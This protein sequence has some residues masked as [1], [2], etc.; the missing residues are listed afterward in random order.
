PAHDPNDFEIGRR[1]SLP[2]PSVIGEDGRITDEAPEEFRGLTVADAQKL[3]VQRLTE[4][5][6]ITRQQP[7]EHD[8]PFSQR[9][10]ERIEPLISLQWFM[11]MDELVKPAIEVVGSGQVRFRPENY[12]RV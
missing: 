8:V 4:Q 5:G 2:Q 3:I 1:H 7:Y 12:T 6:L 10:G 9:S 11:R